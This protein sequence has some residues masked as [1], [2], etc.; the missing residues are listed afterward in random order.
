M[1]PDPGAQPE[2]GELG[3]DDERDGGERAHQD[4]STDSGEERGQDLGELPADEAPGGVGP[5][6]V[7]VE[8]ELGEDRRGDDQEPEAHCLWPAALLRGAE[9]D[10]EGEIEP[11]QG[12]REG[13]DAEESAQRLGR[14][15]AHWPDGVVKTR[16]HPVTDVEGGDREQGEHRGRQ[17][18]HPADGPSSGAPAT[19]LPLLV[20]GPAANRNLLTGQDALF[21]PS[22]CRHARTPL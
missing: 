13:A 19:L 14:R 4:D 21:A 9:E 3:A 6:S 7:L 17:H 11:E 5:Q 15:V 2:E 1:L 20:E 22:F 8:E 12:E 18:H 10:D 16:P